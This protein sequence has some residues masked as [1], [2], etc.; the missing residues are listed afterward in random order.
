[1]ANTPTLYERILAIYPELLDNLE[2]FKNKSIRLQDDG[3]GVFIAKW[4]YSN[5]IPDELAEFVNIQE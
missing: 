3:N 1:M 4:T 5:P 2:E